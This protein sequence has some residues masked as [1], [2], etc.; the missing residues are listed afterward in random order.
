MLKPKDVLKACKP[1]TPGEVLS[2]LEDMYDWLSN[3]PRVEDMAYLEALN[4]CLGVFRLIVEEL[5]E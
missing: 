4:A 3:S 2:Q 5:E 1:L